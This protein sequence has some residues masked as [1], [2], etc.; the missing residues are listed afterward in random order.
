[1]H[2]LSTG[3]LSG[4]VPV[5]RPFH[6]SC[7]A[8]GEHVFLTTKHVV[9]RDDPDYGHKYLCWECWE[10]ICASAMIGYEIR[11]QEVEATRVTQ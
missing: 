6:R 1:M 4:C 2:P 5:S 9:I 7:K 11:M 10:D 8:C 3:P